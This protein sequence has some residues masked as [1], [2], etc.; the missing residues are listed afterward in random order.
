MLGSVTVEDLSLNGWKELDSL[1]WSCLVPLTSLRNLKVENCPQVVSIGATKEEEKEELQQLGIP[2][3]IENLSIED[4]E[5]L[6][7]LSKTLHGELTCLREIHIA[8]CPKLVSLV[9]DSLPSTLK[10]LK[11]EKYGENISFSTTSLLE[12]L[13]IEECKALKSLSSSGNVKIFSV[14][15]KEWTSS[16]VP[17]YCSHKLWKSERGLPTNIQV[18]ELDEPNLCKVV[19]EWGLHRLTSLKDLAIDGSNM[20]V[21]SF[22]QGMNIKLPPSLNDLSITNFKNLR[23]LSSK[24][25]QSLSS[26]QYLSI[27]GC[28]KLKSLPK[29]KVLPSLLRLRIWGC[30]ELKKRCRRD[31]GKYCAYVADIPTSLLKEVSDSMLPCTKRQLTEYFLFAFYDR[32]NE[33]LLKGRF[34]TAVLIRCGFQREVR[35]WNYEFDWPIRKLKGKSLIAI[36]LRCAWNACNYE[37]WRERNCRLHNQGSRSVAQIVQCIEMVIQVIT[38]NLRNVKHDLVNLDLY[39]S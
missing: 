28:P 17:E 12:S 35:T 6:E 3:N 36:V 30:P 10:S 32:M 19:T 8:K 33:T 20:E 13:E 5:G 27:G 16:V 38:A 37:V 39:K 18:L 34:L 4:C 7:N 23:K 11:I 25:F 14:Y 29:K 26:L 24:G 22:P 9:A 1:W 31:K 15:P 2:C 21:V